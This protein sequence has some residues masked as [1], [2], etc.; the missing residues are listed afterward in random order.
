MNKLLQKKSPI[1]SVQDRSSLA[2]CLSAIDLTFMG[3][4]AIIGAGIFVITGIAAAMY[5]GPA[6]I[7]SYILAGITCAL[8]A[9]SY[10][11][12]AASIGGCGSA[13][14][15][16]YASLGE[17]IAWIIGWDLLLEYG[18]SVSTVAIG[19][20]H[21]FRN[22]F[23]ALNFNIPKTLLVGP[24][25]GGLINLPAT[26]IVLFI[27]LLLSMGVKNGARFNTIMV[28]I[29]FSVISFFI[30]IAS[31]H[32]NIQNWHPFMPFGW[33]GVMSGAALIFFAYVG[34]DAV[35]T[36][37]EEVINPQRDL[38]IGILASLA[39]CTLI[40]ILV[41]GLLTG[42]VPY[43]QL[44]V[45]SPIS[46]ALLSLGYRSAAGVIALG[47][48]AGLTTVI[49]VMYYGLTRVFLAMSRDQLLPS[50]FAKI[51]PSTH[52][53][54]RIIFSTGILMAIFSGTIPMAE[55]AELVNIG[56]LAAFALVCGGV[57]VLRYTHPT[58][59][60]PFKT[61]FS[62]FVPLTGIACCLYMMFSLPHITW[63]R[64]GI[65]MVIGSLIYFFYS[66]HRSVAAKTK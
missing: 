39:I 17:L 62:P 8:S 31:G 66:R 65:W 23:T 32:F 18:I 14:G 34:F 49:L 64:F 6:L 47:A 37:A 46:E 22:I 15:Y 45:S 51:H 19:W 38:P 40:Y 10:A 63:L 48:L 1:S 42:M 54:N 60:R 56:T 9:L 44:N 50:V 58:L 13:Y 55:L 57:I 7:I 61:P 29:K 11:E 3:V 36:A 28:L 33:Q 24:F 26:L 5:A 53:P 16:A 12:L 2:P 25:E 4:G 43:P 30:G 27:A 21:Y 35:S 20:S 59:P 41:A 52:T